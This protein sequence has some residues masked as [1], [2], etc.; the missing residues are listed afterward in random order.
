MKAILVAIAA[1]VAIS[2]SNQCQFGA[3]CGDFN[4]I[5]GPSGTPTPRPSPGATPDPCEVAS[6]RIS[7]KGGVQLPYL[8]LGMTEQLDATPFSN[9]GQIPDGCNVVREPVWTVS[10]PLTCQILGNGYNPFV[11]GLRVG[12]CSIYATLG[13]VVSAPFSLEVR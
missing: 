12:N 13:N 11:R 8:G 1:L 9:S 3:I 6:L 7:L 5:G 2:C 10:T 4:V